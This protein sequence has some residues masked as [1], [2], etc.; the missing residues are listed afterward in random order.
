MNTS[1]AILTGALIIGTAIAFTL[2]W[3]IAIGPTQQQNTE[4]PIQ[5]VYRLDRWTGKIVWCAPTPFPGPLRP[6]E[7]TCD[8]P[9]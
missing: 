7:V 5:G 2:R 4:Y 9:K 8:E 3:D 1:A 6:R